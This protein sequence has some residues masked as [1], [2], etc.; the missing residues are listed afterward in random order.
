MIGSVVGQV[1]AGVWIG[2][3][4]AYTEMYRKPEI[5]A[6]W[7]HAQEWLELPQRTQ[8][9]PIPVVFGTVWVRE[10]HVFWVRDLHT[11]T[12]HVSTGGNPQT[13][14]R[15]V[16]QGPLEVSF[17]RLNPKR[18]FCTGLG[19][20]LCQGPLDSVARII[21]ADQ[22]VTGTESPVVDGP[23]MTLNLG[24]EEIEVWDPHLFAANAGSGA[25]G[26]FYDDGV[27]GRLGVAPGK[28]DQGGLVIPRW[29]TAGGNLRG[30]STVWFRGPGADF[31]WD[32]YT[33][34]PQGNK[35]A[36]RNKD[37]LVYEHPYAF[38]FG[39]RPELPP[40]AFLVRRTQGRNGGIIQWNPSKA[41]V[42]TFYDLSGSRVYD[43]N[44]AHIL[45][46]LLCD[47]F[48]GLDLG[49]PTDV[50]DST[51]FEAMADIWFPA[52]TGIG[53]SW[54]WDR[55]AKLLDVV[56]QIE[57]I[58]DVVLEH[59][60]SDNKWHLRYWQSSVTPVVIGDSDIVDISI[61]VPSADEL[62]TTIHVTWQ[63][64]RRGREQ[65]YI[66]Q[67]LAAI[68]VRGR[69]IVH[70]WNT[71]MLASPVMVPV[72]A[73]RE[74]S[75]L[76]T[77]TP[78]V[79]VEVLRTDELAALRITDPVT[80]TSTEHGISGQFRVAEW[81]HGQ[82]TDGTVILTLIGEPDADADT[83]IWHEP[84][85]PTEETPE[86]L[87]DL[88]FVVEEMPLHVWWAIDNV[89]DLPPLLWAV[90][91][92]IDQITRL[93][94]WALRPTDR[95]DLDGWHWADRLLNEAGAPEGYITVSP[96]VSPFSASF[97]VTTLNRGS[98]R[99]GVDE[100]EHDGTR[101]LRVGDILAVPHTDETPIVVLDS[102]GLSLA[103]RGNLAS[104]NLDYGQ[105]DGAYEFL[106]VTEVVDSTH[107][108]VVGGLWDTLPAKEIGG[109]SL[110]IGHYPLIDPWD[111][112]PDELQIGGAGQVR[113]AP[114]TIGSPLA[115]R[116]AVQTSA[117]S[118]SGGRIQAFAD[119][120]PLDVPLSGVDAPAPAAQNAL[121]RPIRPLVGGGIEL[122]EIDA[123]ADSRI[124]IVV[125]P[126]TRDSRQ[127]APSGLKLTDI[128]EQTQRECCIWPDTTPPLILWVIDPSSGNVIATR[129]WTTAY[130]AGELA[131]L[132][133][134]EEALHN[135]IHG[136]SELFEE[137]TLIVTA[138]AA[139]IDTPPGTL[140]SLQSWQYLR[141][142]L[143]RD[144]GAGDPADLAG[145]TLYKSAINQMNAKHLTNQCLIGHR[146]DQGVEGPLMM[147]PHDGGAADWEMSHASPVSTFSTLTYFP[148]IDSAGAFAYMGMEGDGTVGSNSFTIFVKVD[149]SDGSID[150]SA[151]LDPGGEGR[152][153]GAYCTALD[154]TGGRV[155][156][157][158]DDGSNEIK[159]IDDDGT[160]N[161]IACNDALLTNLA[162]IA[163]SENDDYLV[164]LSDA[165]YLAQWALS[166]LSGTGNQF[167]GYSTDRI[168]VGS[169]G[170]TTN[171]F[172]AIQRNEG[173]ARILP[174]RDGSNTFW[175]CA[176]DSTS[177]DP[178]IMQ[179]DPSVTPYT[180]RIVT[181][182]DV[183]ADMH[184]TD[185]GTAHVRDIAIDRDG[186][187][188]ALIL[189][190][191]SNVDYDVVRYNAD[192]TFDLSFA[193]EGVTIA[194]NGTYGDATR[195]AV[196][197]NY[198]V[199]VGT[200]DGYVITYSQ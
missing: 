9:E 52:G 40:W 84:D 127:F 130:S 88:T 73:R 38:Y 118:V 190:G 8:G 154:E 188:Y 94:M 70:N 86:A 41:F 122:F 179:Y 59:E 144:L 14:R 178:F 109:T 72:L 195:I 61:D 7:P 36:L 50:I 93:W 114:P 44:P 161:G 79:E 187:I 106:I 81:S 136:T 97:D 20:V 199:Y 76:T 4:Q 62:P 83:P 102:S 101:V 167:D 119:I 166:G 120:T 58:G 152:Q 153:A 183:S 176:G 181:E 21:A 131:L 47:P 138:D 149:L 172:N 192:G 37:G 11:Q 1:I 169:G 171:A 65:T 32:A 189:P 132:N 30:V 155:F 165:E 158:T 53:L 99:V 198:N 116:N 19:M 126:R 200:E 184:P 74:L 18:R 87:P 26:S 145:P 147:I 24:P 43:M 28:D 121:T 139:L 182:V 135:T 60:P 160:S 3:V 108:N 111:C 48:W 46:E 98:D 100:L 13:I 75:R 16:G 105:M 134:D 49:D 186:K 141:F 78:T 31:D 125:E 68:H 54:L 77:P 66:L 6:L 57:R 12:L 85:D 42:D 25:E 117:L 163:V 64:R 51:S 170:D 45:V 128:S 112:A 89:P 140:K 71:V 69:E 123:G 82:R 129:P 80:L 174:S 33:D 164:A 191:T 143:S 91:S 148:A 185:T 90:G 146:H 168:D 35:L 193:A 39:A 2:G 15:G 197:E 196:D 133:S 10:P 27:A 194:A 175:F 92:D 124:S 150:T 63:D 157:T 17:G 103:D 5:P 159:C 110:V 151:V 95:W 55:E 67:D 142:D 22:L 115:V 113:R 34:D 104:R 162:G 137:L 56:Q 173:G 29:G 156:I 107:V 177:D 23:A 180:D 96:E